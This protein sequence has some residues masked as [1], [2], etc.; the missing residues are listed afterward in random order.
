MPL[1]PEGEGIGIESDQ[2]GDEGAT[3]AYHHA[4]ADQRVR[5]DPVLEYGGRHVLAAR[6]D[7]QLL[8]AAGDPQEA[9]VIQFADV[10]GVQAA[11]RVE[12]VA[13]GRR[14]VPVAGEYVRPADQD[15]AVIGDPYADSRQRHADRPYLVAARPVHGRGR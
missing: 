10:P 7:D 6:G 1:F 4:L 9:L 2:A 8:L 11:V 5:A 12:H 15:L 13:G 14:I 3:V